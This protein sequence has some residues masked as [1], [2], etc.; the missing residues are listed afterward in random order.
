VNPP[1]RNIATKQHNKK[2][3]G[4]PA[5]LWEQSPSSSA[6]SAGAVT[7]RLESEV[8]GGE[9]GTTSGE[10]AALRSRPRGAGDVASSVAALLA[11]AARYAWQISWY[12]ATGKV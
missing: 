2:F 9:L 10:A 8:C 4:S 7:V 12:F 5:Q 1:T 3:R 11:A 6:S